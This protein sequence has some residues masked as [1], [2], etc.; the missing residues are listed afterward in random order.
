MNHAEKNGTKIVVHARVGREAYPILALS[1]EQGSAK[2][3][4]SR[5]LQSL[6][7]PNAAG[8]RGVV[9][10][11]QD[12]FIAARNSH[13]LC[14]DNLS[15]L[16]D[17]LADDLCRIATGA[18]FTTRRLFRDE[19]EVVISVSRP[20]I[21]NGIPDLLSRGD[22]A[23]RCLNL[24]L[25]SISSEQRMPE[26]EYWAKV[27]AVRAQALGGLFTALAGA[28]A[29]WDRTQLAESPRMAD[30]AKLIMAAEPDLPWAPGAFMQAYQQA[31]MEAA[32]IT[33]EGDA[34]AQELK[35][36][37][38]AVGAWEGTAWQLLE[39]LDAAL[40]GRDRP[41]GW[42]R[43]AKAASNALRR[44]APALRAGGLQIS[45]ERRAGG[46]R[47]RIVRLKQE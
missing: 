18:S 5:L 34:F 27:E 8:L 29:R 26:Q 40:V 15:A 13:V 4:T 36:F 45:H 20:M 1:G 25:G 23:D 42:P 24:T 43:T 46:N 47:D 33:L 2:S 28:L 21:L 14:L 39:A 16:N 10:E 12:L 44:L 6:V 17:R 31:R 19:D 35:G 11:G 22:L 38:Q 9:K 30:F 37:V 7:D 41:E 32:S 3:S